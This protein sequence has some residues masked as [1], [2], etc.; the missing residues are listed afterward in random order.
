MKTRSRTI[1]LVALGTWLL[2][3]HDVNAADTI[4][5]VVMYDTGDLINLRPEDANVRTRDGF[6]EITGVPRA[7]K[8]GMDSYAG[9]FG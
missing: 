2:V 9:W 8:L 6:L 1:A 3:P 4:D 7:P 5:Y